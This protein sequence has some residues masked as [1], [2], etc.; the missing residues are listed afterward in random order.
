MSVV[1]GIDPGVTGAVAV[2]CGDQWIVE[3]CPTNIA[4]KR[5]TRRAPKPSQ[6]KSYK[7]KTHACDP[8]G[9]AALL[10]EYNYEDAQVFV[11]KVGPMKGQGVTSMFGFGMGYGIWLGVLATLQLP[12]TLVTPQAWK[13]EMLIGVGQEKGASIARAKQLFPYLSDCL[14]RAKDDGRAEAIL[15]GEYGRRLLGC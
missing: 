13:K 8:A 7:S 5:K 14:T 1:I 3:D 4:V 11:E 15:I 2:Y 12:Y 6:S 9:M 10:T